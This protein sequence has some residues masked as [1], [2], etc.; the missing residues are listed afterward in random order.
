MF[1]LRNVELRLLGLGHLLQALHG[2]LVLLFG[3]PSL[4][5]LGLETLCK[6]QLDVFG[7][8]VWVVRWCEDELMCLA[9]DLR[10]SFRFMLSPPLAYPFPFP[11]RIA[12]RQ[13]RR[14]ASRRQ[15]GRV[16]ATA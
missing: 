15:S 8:R 14:S 9:F 4:C 3:A 16:G 5:R 13:A 10:L 12:S 1:L 7:Y 11:E 6:L 2:G